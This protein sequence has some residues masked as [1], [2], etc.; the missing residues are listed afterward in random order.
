MSKNDGKFES[1][2]SQEPNAKRLTHIIHGRNRNAHVALQRMRGDEVTSTKRHKETPKNQPVKVF[3]GGR[4][5]EETLTV[6]PS[7]QLSRKKN[8]RTD[9]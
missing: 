2:T 8:C 1:R 3:N 6:P 4:P 5:E 9:S 7:G